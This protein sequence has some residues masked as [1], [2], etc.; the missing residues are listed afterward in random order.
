MKKLLSLVLLLTLFVITGCVTEVR[1]T[2]GSSTGHLVSSIQV[3]TSGLNVNSM[4]DFHEHKI[5]EKME[6]GLR[7]RL[8]RTNKLSANGAA[9]VVT[10]TDL[11]IH[12]RSAVWAVGFMVGRDKILAKVQIVQGGKV[13]REFSATT[14]RFPGVL[15]GPGEEYR[16][17]LLCDH[18]ADD[19]TRQL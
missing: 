19:L 10:I 6:A 4:D 16:V 1:Q 8:S 5:A 3:T 9:L 7:S 11:H 17:R 15:T 2:S 13:V 18:L 14:K 12:S